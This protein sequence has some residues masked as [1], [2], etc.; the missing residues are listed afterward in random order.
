MED[1]QKNT[2]GVIFAVIIVFAWIAM[3]FMQQF[4]DGFTV[5]PELQGL[6][7]ATVVLVIGISTPVGSIVGKGI[8]KVA[9]G[10][11]NVL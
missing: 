10:I 11:K 1:Y 8:K 4:I 3:L 5:S 9:S 2:L 6:A 7:I